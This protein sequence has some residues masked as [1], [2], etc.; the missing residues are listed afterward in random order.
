MFK[1]PVGY[2]TFHPIDQI[3][4]Q[5]NRWLPT[6]DEAEFVQA[7]REV[8]QGVVADAAEAHRWFT[9]HRQHHLHHEH[10]PQLVAWRQQALALI[11]ERDRREQLAAS[12]SKAAQILAELK[13]RAGMGVERPTE[14]AALETATTLR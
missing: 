14:T 3:N 9:M 2:R 10:E 6:A 7:G 8:G 13:R 12:R 11:E 4:Y 1:F 5:I